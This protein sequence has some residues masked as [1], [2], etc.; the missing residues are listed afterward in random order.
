[1]TEKELR[2]KIARQIVIYNL[3]LFAALFIFTK[4]LPGYDPEAG[5]YLFGILVPSTSIYLSSWIMFTIKNKYQ[6]ADVTSKPLHESFV[7]LSRWI[8]PLH[9]WLLLGAVSWSALFKNSLSFESL[10]AFFTLEESLFGGY[11]GI[12]ISDLFKYE[13]K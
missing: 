10:K 2:R 1:M 3:L 11:T 9:F 4:V 8:I 5:S 6:A 12:I 7:N 13:T